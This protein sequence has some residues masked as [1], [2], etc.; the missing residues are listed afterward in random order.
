MDDEKGSLLFQ[1]QL[2]DVFCS[3][4]FYSLTQT[5]AQEEIRQIRPLI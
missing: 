5:Y 4:K 1:R 2:E 3:L